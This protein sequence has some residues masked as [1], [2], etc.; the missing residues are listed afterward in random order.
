M[1]GCPTFFGTPQQLFEVAATV[2]QIADKL[3]DKHPHLTGSLSHSKFSLRVAAPSEATLMR[4]GKAA[5]SLH[6]N[7]NTIGL[8]VDANA[9]FA[10][11]TLDDMQMLLAEMDTGIDTHKSLGLAPNTTSPGALTVIILTYPKGVF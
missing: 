7:P 8:D 3:A 2:K 1:F 4:L 6:D 5:A 11:K 10:V 9:F